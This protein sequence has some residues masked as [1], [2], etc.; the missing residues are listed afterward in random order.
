MD[1]Y[2]KELLKYAK[3]A[4]LNAYAPYS[5]FKV[6]AAVLSES[7]R[8]FK[9]C[10][11]ENVTYGATICAERSAVSNAVVSGE[12]KF[13]AIA[14]TAGDDEIFPCGICRQVLSEFSTDLEVICDSKDGY[15]V[16]KLSELLPHS[17]HDFKPEE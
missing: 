2:R 15:N 11:V 10:N 16:Y 12:T 17:F 6:G 7:G 3:E 4:R 8:I 14:I 1:H 9:G 13:K 5:G